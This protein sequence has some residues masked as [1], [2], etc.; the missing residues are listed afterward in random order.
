MIS[1]LRLQSSTQ[2]ATLPSGDAAAA[3][4]ANV[5]PA[6]ASSSL[7][8][9]PLSGLPVSPRFPAKP[10]ARLTAQN[11]T[12]LT[13]QPQALNTSESQPA[14]PKLGCSASPVAEA[15]SQ[16]PPDCLQ[17]S[18]SARGTGIN[19]ESA[20]EELNAVVSAEMMHLKPS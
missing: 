1:S 4:A 10:A 17:Q 3:A 9:E 11:R 20:G 13:F 15:S 6:H 19:Q 8:G 14:Q 7:S 5:A 2:Y 16:G 12:E 18:R